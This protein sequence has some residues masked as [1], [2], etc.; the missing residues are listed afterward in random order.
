MEPPVRFL[1]LEHGG[2]DD[3]REGQR[4]HGEIDAGQPHREPAEQQRAGERDQRRGD[5][6]DAHRHGEPFHQQRRAIGAEAE[7]GGVAERVHA[8]GAGDE[9]QRSGEDHGDQHVDAEDQQIRR[10]LRQQR[11]QQ[12]QQQRGERQR[13]ERRRRRT[14]RRFRLGD[15]AHRGLRAA[16]Q[17]IRA[18][19][20]DRRHHQ[21]FG[22][23][24]QLGEVDAD[25]AEI[26]HADADA[27]RLDL[28]DDDGGQVGAGDRAHAADHDDDEG[29]ADRGEIGAEIGRLAR[30]L[31]R[32]A[33]AGE[34]GAEREHGGE[35]QRLIDAERADHLA[36]LR[37]RAHQPAETRARQRNMQRDQ[38]QRRDGGEEQVVARQMAAENFDGAA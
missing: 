17:A 28:G 13:L 22:D 4:Q 7:I 20:E 26:D 38:R 32:A 8:A 14:Q 12:Q 34:R 35:Q 16:E 36:V 2:P 11:Q 29:V 27:D 9:M 10:A 37:R 1:P 31:Q 30:H 3:L 15:R 25:E 5:E 33:E 18:S 21:E 23:Q 19:N 6:P 24:R